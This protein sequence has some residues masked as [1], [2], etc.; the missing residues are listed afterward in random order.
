[1]VITFYRVIV[2]VFGAYNITSKW[3]FSRFDEEMLWKC[4]EMNVYVVPFKCHLLPSGVC[5]VLNTPS[6][7][8][9]FFA[10]SR[11]CHSPDVR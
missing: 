5:C 6:V 9:S 10:C 1:M 2:P 7:G 8:L 11:S 4:A 3:L